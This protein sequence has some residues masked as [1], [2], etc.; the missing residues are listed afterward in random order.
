MPFFK[1]IFLL[2]VSSYHGNV[3]INSRE[4][5]SPWATTLLTYLQ[6][7]LFRRGRIHV[8]LKA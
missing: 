5:Q 2:F 4:L 8:Q 6:P 3:P 1:F 7:E